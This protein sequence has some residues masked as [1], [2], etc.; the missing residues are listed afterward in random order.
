MSPTVIVL[1]LLAV[2]LGLGALSRFKAPRRRPIFRQNDIFAGRLTEGLVHALISDRGYL[3][4]DTRVVGVLGSAVI[5]ERAG[6]CGRLV[7][8]PALGFGRENDLPG[9]SDLAA[10]RPS[11]RATTMVVIGGGEEFGRS[12]FKATAP[13]RTLH[14][15]DAGAVREARARFRSSSP[16][17]VIESALDRM[18]ADLR[19]GAFPSVDFET[20]RSLVT[21]AS[22][23]ALRPPPPLRGV[24]TTALTVAI[25]LCFAVEVFI[26]PDSFGGGG[27]TL[28]VAYR[29]GAIYQ[30]AIL[31]GE[32]QRL[33]AA[34]FLHFGLLHLAMNGWAQWSLGAPIEFLVGP[35]RFFALWVG[36]ALGASLTSLIFN[37]SSV[38]AGASG[39]I[40]G[41][42]GA[43]TTFIFFRKDVLPQPV[44]RPLRNGVLATLLL[45]LMISFIPGIDMAAH[46][47]GFLT[48]AVMAFGLVKRDRSEI[49]APSRPGPL[50]LA[51]AALVL[52]GVGLTSIQERA[53]L[54]TR[55]PEIGTE[56]AVAE[57]RLPIPGGFTVSES[58]TKGL[59][60]V[61]SEGGPA[62]PFSVTYKI[63][64]PQADENAA[65]RVLKTL[66]PEPVAVQDSDWIAVSQM[67]IQNLRAIEIVVA[68][69]ASCSVKAEKLAADL[70]SGVR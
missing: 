47:G 70:A 10:R 37:D 51:V 19:E 63:S 64:E 6:A 30:S 68:A 59:T 36:S 16:R 12:A 28:T 43:F 39:A 18:A 42:L 5:I 38:A 49:L 50:R 60:V 69:P 4:T 54:S 26:S 65:R 34:P 17:L 41:L 9:L 11:D 23:H 3:R 21:D 15:D 31:A 25:V 55:V 53:D 52:L 67:G 45:N 33:I 14:I 8:C 61:E 22:E 46:A 13:A 44:P 27:A 66:H 40:F 7:L 2:F 58:R 62:S 56:H 48:G 57:L 32:W 1:G 20:V 35:W 29:M 24:V